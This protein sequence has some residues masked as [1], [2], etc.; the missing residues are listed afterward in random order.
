MNAPLTVSTDTATERVRDRMRSEIL[1]GGFQPGARLKIVEIAA[2]YGISPIPV[3]EAMRLLAG[4]GLIEMIAH[5]GAVV[6]QVD[7]NFII[8]MYDI[9]AA[10]EGMLAERAIAVMRPAT[11]KHI[12]AAAAD[13]AKAATK[14]KLR[15]LFDANSAFHGEINE[16]A[17]NPEAARMVVGGTAMIRAI[18]LR[19]GMSPERAAINI[20]Q[21]AAIVAALEAK[22]A[23]AAAA[24]VRIHCIT[25]RDDLLAYWD[26][27][28]G[29]PRPQAL[30]GA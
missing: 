23:G 20:A 29:I 30:T 21:H 12:R 10:L 28:A 25:G 6:R 3:R 11:L 8:D 27:E 18:R 14:L 22:D 16:A 2:R 19:I 15:A 13:Y 7:R 4:E 1:D 26:A 17:N 9:R 5:R 24:A